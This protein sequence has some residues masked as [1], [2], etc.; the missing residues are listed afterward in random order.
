M[1]KVFEIAFKLGGELTSSFKQAF[2]EADGAL[3]MVGAAAAALG[4]TAALAG[5]ASQVIDMNESFTQLSAQ[6]GMVG[7]DL[8]ELKGVAENLFR[9]NYGEDFNE[10]TAALANVKQNMHDLNEADLESFTGNALMFSKTFEADINEVTRAANNMMSAF[11]VES[12]KAMDLFASGAQRGLNFS[13]EMLDN[14]AEYAPLFGEMGYSAEEYFGIMERGAKAGVY[15]L[16]Y[17]NDAMKEFQIR[18][19]DNSDKTSDYMSLM[20]Q[21]T[22]DLWEAQY[23]GKATVAEVA[24]SV[25]KDLQAMDNQVDANEAGVALFGTKWED[26]E[27]TAIYAMLGTTDAMTDFEGAMEEINQIQFSSFGA[28]IQGIGRM[29][30]M[31]IVYPVANMALP[32]LNDFANYLQENFPSAIDTTVNT[33]RAVTPPILGLTAAF[34]TYRSVLMLATAAKTAYTTILA[35]GPSLLYAYRTATL[36]YTFAGGGMV[37]VIVA[38]R[39]GIAALNLTVL[40]NPFALAAAAIVGLVIAFVAAYKTSE[41]FRNVVNEVFSSTKNAVM[42]AVNY[43]S[44]SAP[45][46]WDR[47]LDSLKEMKIR[48]FE[49]I[50]AVASQTM[51]FFGDGITGKVNS[52]VNGFVESFKNGLSS[53]PGII[54]MVAPIMTT[55][56]LGFLGVSGPIGWLIGAIVSIGGFL[57]RLAQTNDGVASSLS[58]AWSSLQ[59]AFA[60]VIDVLNDGLAQFVEGVGPQF[61]ETMSV[62]AQS[63]IELGPSFAML[64]TTLGELIPV[65]LSAGSQ[66][67]TTFTTT[68]F[69]VL[70]EAFQLVFTSIISI[71]TTVVPIIV[72]ALMLVIPIFL[73]IAQ[74]VIP[75]I[76][77]AVQMVFPIV[78]SIIQA[79]LPIFVQLLT[80]V[81]SVILTLAQTVIPILLAVVQM[82]FPMVLGVIQMVIPIIAMILQTVVTVLNTVV[83]PAINLLLSVVQIVFPYIQMVIQ[84]ALAIINGILQAAMALL[85]GDWEGA[86]NA[87]KGTAETIMNNIIGFFQGI[88]LYQVGISIINGLIDGIKSMGGSVLGAIGNLVPGPVKG[89]ISS[90]LPEFFADGGIVASPTLAWIGEGGDTEAVI[91]WNNSKRS[92]DLWVQTGQQLGMLQEN[93]V[94]DNMEQQIT[95]RS[96]ANDNPAIRPEEVVRTVSSNETKIIQL[97]YNPQYNVQKPEDLERVKKHADKDKDDLKARLEQIERDERRKSFGD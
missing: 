30:F 39:S 40:A 27:S 3:K 49:E 69:P 68:V 88:N 77:S 90:I 46:M 76:L 85:K 47:L 24:S 35:L 57:F 15:N 1:S 14:V 92:R 45:R 64:A 74:T 58:S 82:V 80:T 66:M 8:Q 78:L 18:I 10:V 84:N 19:K 50:R 4:G 36:A 95:M 43:I 34:V 96:E 62:I 42:D 38:L 53:L 12:S 23:Q 97:N 28:A 73:H 63:V 13:D 94:F 60:P 81:V 9:N 91:P 17:V 44:T 25:V 71:I 20:S 55:L 89:V 52:I 22:L 75:L 41:R 6:T 51:D 87:I 93:G 37:G 5:I 16:D 33:L 32:Y 83:I 54:S 48:L 26:L 70:L 79:V 29:L 21:S 59:T 2:G 7:D 65:L 72:N 56:A 11:G 86:W 31:D 67:V 61:S